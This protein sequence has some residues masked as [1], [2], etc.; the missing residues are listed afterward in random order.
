MFTHLFPASSKL[1][2]HDLSRR[3]FAYSPRYS[4]VVCCVTPEQ[5]AL[6]AETCGFHV[7]PCP[8]YLVRFYRLSSYFSSITLPFCVWPM[9]GTFHRHQVLPLP[10]TTLPWSDVMILSP[11]IFEKVWNPFLLT[12]FQVRR[13]L[14]IKTNKCYKHAVPINTTN[15]YTKVW[16][17]IIDTQD[18]VGLLQRILWFLT[19]AAEG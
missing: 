12:A 13:S 6:F 17:K 10:S 14:S 4:V 11:C 8:L 7:L 15:W 16:K 1:K 2:L 3:H 19:I 9:S 18:S 5:V